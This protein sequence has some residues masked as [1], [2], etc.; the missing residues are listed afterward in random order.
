MSGEAPRARTITENRPKFDPKTTP[1]TTKIAPGV[2]RG[3]LGRFGGHQGRSQDLPGELGTP[4]ESPQTAPGELPDAPGRFK[5]A[6]ERSRGVFFERLVLTPVF[7]TPLERFWDVF[8]PAETGPDVDFTAP[9]QCFVKV[10]RFS[11]GRPIDH[12]NGRSDERTHWK[13]LAHTFPRI[14]F[15]SLEA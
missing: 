1:Q 14:I 9:C 2:H 10:E 5:S 3:V 8:G 4:P 6:P 12:Q 15:L 11:S 7:E 13:C